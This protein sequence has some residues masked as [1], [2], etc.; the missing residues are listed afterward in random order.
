M[1]KTVRA[2]LILFVA[3]SCVPYIEKTSNSWAQDKPASES[4]KKS[5]DEPK[6]KTPQQR[7][8]EKMKADIRQ[9]IFKL[10]LDSEMLQKDIEISKGQVA[11]ISERLQ[12]YTKEISEARREYSRKRNEA[13]ANGER[14]DRIWLL[15][16]LDEVEAEHSKKIKTI[17][18]KHQIRRVDQIA[19]Q[20]WLKVYHL[21]GFGGSYDEFLIPIAAAKEIGLEKEDADKLQKVIEEKRSE[22]YEEVAKLR[23]KKIREIVNSLP[24]EPKRKFDESIGPLFNFS[25]AQRTKTR[26]GLKPP[27]PPKK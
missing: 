11:K 7:N 18:L 23:K 22:F 14:I 3:I 13:R 6:T 27:A 19:K 10:V 24:A 1:H 16:R 26:R 8:I 9:H 25:E 20:Y 4:T 17:L 15:D 21:G 5:A 12:A 2:Y